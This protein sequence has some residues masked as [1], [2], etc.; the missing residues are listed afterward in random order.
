MSTS[1]HTPGPWHVANGVQIR[2][3]RDQ[4]A[5]VWMMRKGEGKA[6]AQLIATAPRLLSA[7]EDITPP[8]PP[9]N[10]P[11]HVGL[12][13]QSQC[14]HCTRIA[15]ARAAIKAARGEAE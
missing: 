5:R 13:P 11:C 10:A 6:N 15:N 7:L 4:I 1:H 8:M 12:V 2:S 9:E 3:G 14:A